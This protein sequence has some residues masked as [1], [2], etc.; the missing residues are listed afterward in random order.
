MQEGADLTGVPN[1]KIQ[2]F[3]DQLDLLWWYIAR[4]ADMLPGTEGFLPMKGE[5]QVIKLHWSHLAHDIVAAGLAASPPAHR[6]FWRDAY[7]D[8]RPTTIYGG[9]SQLRRNVLA[10]QV[11]RL[12]KR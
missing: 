9:S 5:S 12:R 3:R 6:A 8:A 7:L 2:G 4:A 10:D 1:P 11:M